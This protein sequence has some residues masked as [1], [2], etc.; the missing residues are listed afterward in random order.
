MSCYLTTA[1]VTDLIAQ[2]FPDCIV[3][4]DSQRFLVLLEN[5]TLATLCIKAEYYCNFITI[6]GT[7]FC[8]L[9]DPTAR[10]PD[11]GHL[12]NKLVASSAQKA[13]LASVLASL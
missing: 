11:G 4:R 8:R 7:E 2:E 10:A 5:T 1:R 12:L 13:E 6:G 3:V 9:Q